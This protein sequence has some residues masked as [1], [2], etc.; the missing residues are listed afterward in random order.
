[1]SIPREQITGLVLAGGRGSRMGGADKG[2]QLL[3]G[4]P[5][6]AHALA[7]LTPQVGGVLINANRN[8]EAYAAF[9]WPVCTDALPDHPGPLAGM[10]AGLERCE[11]PWLLTVP[12]DSP[13]LPADLAA[14]LAAAAVHNIADI[15][16]P[17]T[18]EDGHPQ[19]QPVFCLLRAS[20][21]T[22]LAQALA[23]G[24]RTIMRWVAR[25]RSVQVPFRDQPQAFFNANTGAELQHLESR[26]LPPL[27][28]GGRGLG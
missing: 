13:Q 27:P 24:E 15:A 23:E 14:R 25:H 1:M 20:L 19:V 9:G 5:L 21:R 11:T 16:L 26:A 4:Q 6:V 12:C 18:P 3:Q 22:S 8:L 2:L 28:R 17:V 7:R 10:L